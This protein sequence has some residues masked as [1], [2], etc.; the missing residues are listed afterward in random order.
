MK[1]QFKSLFLGGLLPVIIFTV[2]EE[3]YGTLWGLVAGMIFGVGEIL[4][5]LYS[6]GK[7][8]SMTWGGN[9]IL[10]VLGGISLITQE[11]LWFKL[12]PALIE[13]AF[14]GILWGSLFLKKSLL[15]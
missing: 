12:Q 5:E 4:W 9:G 1:A 14:A 10:L 2:I 6:R 11:G 8:D 3:Y 15:L 13:I 7:V